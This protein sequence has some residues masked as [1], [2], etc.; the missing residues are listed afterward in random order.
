MYVG[1]ASNVGSARCHP[2]VRRLGGAGRGLV[3][4][5]Q[6]GWSSNAETR[7][8]VTGCKPTVGN[9]LDDNHRNVWYVDSLLLTA[10]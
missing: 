9:R 6:V 7:R 3:T 1:T 5:V 10:R 4:V 8:Y 2:V